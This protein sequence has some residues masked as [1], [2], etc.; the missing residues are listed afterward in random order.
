MGT[1]SIQNRH[2]AQLPPLPLTQAGRRLG[3]LRR[4]AVTRKSLWGAHFAGYVSVN[5]FLAFI[6]FMTGGRMPWFLIVAGAWAIPLLMHY[7]H[8]RRREHLQ[9]KL[10][11]SIRIP[12]HKY[13]YFKKLHRSTSHFIMGLTTAASVSGFLFLV[14]GL[15]GHSFWSII[16]AASIG[17]CALFYFWFFRARRAA[18]IQRLESDE[19]VYVEEPSVPLPTAP[20]ETGIHPLLAEARGLAETIRNSIDASGPKQMELLA[21]LDEMLAE[22]ERL[23]ALESEFARAHS[24]ISLPELEKDREMVKDM[25]ESDLSGPTRRQYEST[26]TQLDRQIASYKELGHRHELVQLRIRTSVNSL[27]QLNVDLV[28][29]KGDTAL[30]EMNQLVQE[31]ADELSSYLSDLQESYAELSEEIH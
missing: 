12:D 20:S 17:L 10:E 28:R 3:K 21:N 11:E 29:I 19:H 31:K 7:V 5:A 2:G 9:R 23:C 27:R 8:Y 18:L 6:D 4:R 26:L 30:S 13:R 1:N 15:T 14:N 25:L 16:P 24:L 22:I